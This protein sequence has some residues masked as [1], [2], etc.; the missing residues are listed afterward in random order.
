MA[1]IVTIET[2]QEFAPQIAVASHDKIR[3]RLASPENIEPAGLPA[4]DAQSWILHRT[5]IHWLA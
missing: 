2:M 5:S 4:V 3:S 1:I